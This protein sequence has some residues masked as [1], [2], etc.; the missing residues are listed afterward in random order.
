METPENKT[1]IIALFRQG[2]VILED[3]LNG[4]D[5]TELDYLP[6]KKGWTIRQ[7]VHH[8]A[9]GD[10]LWKIG[11]KIALGNEKAEFNLQWYSAYQQTEWAKYWNYEK[12]G[13][14]TSISFLKAS[15]THVLQLLE[16]VDNAWNKTVRF[17]KP[18]G[19]IETVPVGFVIQMQAN[20]VVHHVKRIKEIRQEFL[21]R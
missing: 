4:I 17:L 2:P 20:H 18:D 21:S 14:E 5:E 3:S 9:D 15:R 12:R 19:V 10:D 11:I 6:A 8:L 13:I 7:I 1:E 16:S